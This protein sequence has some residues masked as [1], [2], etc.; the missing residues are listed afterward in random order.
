MEHKI[1]TQ[2]VSPIKQYARQV[3]HAMRGKI[4]ELVTGMLEKGVIEPSHSP[5]ASPIVLVAKKDGSTH[6][7]IDYCK[8]NAVTK[9]D[10][11]P[12]PRIDD[13]IDILEGAKYFLTLDQAFGK[14]ECRRAQLRR[15]RLPPTVIHSNFE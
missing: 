15:W 7:C 13:C 1:D 2:G 14:S 11:F 4:K 6:F 5:W 12:L 3:L 10:V 8:L 9:P